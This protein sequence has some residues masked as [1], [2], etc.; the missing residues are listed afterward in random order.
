MTL[1]AQLHGIPAAVET[2]AKPLI[3][4]GKATA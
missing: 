1:P 3:F 4:E 2:A